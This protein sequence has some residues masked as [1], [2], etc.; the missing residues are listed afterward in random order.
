MYTEESG[1]RDFDDVVFPNAGAVCRFS[2]FTRNQ[3]GQI[4][5]KE[6]PSGAPGSDEVADYVY[7]NCE[8]VSPVEHAGEDLPLRIKLKG[9]RCYQDD[10][11]AWKFHLSGLALDS[12]FRPTGLF[13]NAKE[14]GF[15][16]TALD[17]QSQIGYEVNEAG[18]PV[19]I[20]DEVERLIEVATYPLT[21]VQVLDV[22][23]E[24]K[25]KQ[26]AEAGHLFNVRTSE[27]SWII[28]NSLQALSGEDAVTIQAQ[29]Q[30]QA[31]AGEAQA[32]AIRQRIREGQAE[33]ED[34][35]AFAE[36]VRAYAADVQPDVDGGHLLASCTP[37]TLEHIQ[38]RLWPATTEAAP[39]PAA[40]TAL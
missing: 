8:I 19:Y 7:A 6:K 11:G 34:A 21:P 17:P 26:A 31:A 5:V 22:V 24:P 20:A 2:G 9:I 32:E 10:V 13:Q 16:T 1:A 4:V 39:T 14:M 36:R 28:W 18:V 29:A 33:A 15:K 3:D 40:V 27:I 38:N 37:A 25:L 30:A 35:Q 23:I 12:E